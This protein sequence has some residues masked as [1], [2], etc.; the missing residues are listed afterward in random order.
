MALFTEMGKLEKEA[1]FS[2][3]FVC[4]NTRLFCFV[5]REDMISLVLGKWNGPI[6]S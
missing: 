6:G 3:C 2:P 1:D 4:L 5:C